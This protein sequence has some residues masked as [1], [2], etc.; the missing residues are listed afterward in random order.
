MA[1][2]TDIV[3]SNNDDGVNHWFTVCLT[4]GRNREVRRLWESQDVQV[5]RLKRVRYGPIFMPS[6]VRSGQWID[7]QEKDIKSLYQA[8][9]IKTPKLGIK[10]ASEKRRVKREETRLRAKNHSRRQDRKSR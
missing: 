5:N 7:L 10:S 8:C 1:R 6:Y 3:E 4:E 2:F 9:D